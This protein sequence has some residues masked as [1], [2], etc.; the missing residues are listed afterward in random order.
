MSL[1]FIE[2]EPEQRTLT[3]DA[4]GGAFQIANSYNYNERN[5]LNIPA[6]LACVKSIAEGFANCPVQ[7]LEDGTKEVKFHPVG[8]AFN[9]EPNEESTAYDYKIALIH[10]LLLWG[11]CFTD[12]KTDKGGEL[13]PESLR[14]CLPNFT[15]VMRSDNRKVVYWVTQY[16]GSETDVISAKE[17]IH[18]KGLTYDSI[19]GISPIAACRLAFQLAVNQEQYG[20]KWF[21]NNSQPGGFYTFP[22]QLSPQGRDNIVKSHQLEFAGSRNANKIGI[23][24]EGGEYKPNFIPQDD[25]QFLS[26]RT[27]QLSEICRIFNLPPYFIFAESGDIE[28]EYPRYVNQSLLPI[29]NRFEMEIKKKLLGFNNRLTINFDVTGLL[30][31]NINTRYSVYTTAL[32]NGIMNINEVRTFEGMEGIGPKGDEYRTPLNM[33]DN[34]ANNDIKAHETMENSKDKIEGDN[35]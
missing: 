27:F 26:S 1:Q 23:L 19:I 33:S 11:N 15:R 34:G 20:N 5:V 2:K 14:L 22:N 32:Q 18:C 13:E 21:E 30:R 35:G 7:I 17:M 16:P 31:G 25:G 12:F 8:H 24:D 4:F 9:Y 28:K 3:S 29:I 10:H 6:A